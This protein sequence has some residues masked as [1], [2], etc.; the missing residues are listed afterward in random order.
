MEALWRGS[1]VYNPIKSQ[2][3]IK[4]QWPCAS[5]HKTCVIPVEIIALNRYRSSLRV[6]PQFMY[7]LLRVVWLPLPF[8]DF[9]PCPLTDRDPSFHYPKLFFIPWCTLLK[10]A[11]HRSFHCL[12]VSNATLSCRSE[13]LLFCSGE[14]LE[15]AVQTTISLILM[16]LDVV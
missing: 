11:G 15:C 13:K 10:W 16:R 4:M 2:Q 9:A 14:K 12:L 5:T 8:S 6:A 3:C 1:D 7:T